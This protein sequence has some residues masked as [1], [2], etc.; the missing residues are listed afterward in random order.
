MHFL[1]SIGRFQAPQWPR[2]R[3][4][5][6][7]WRNVHEYWLG[8]TREHPSDLKNNMLVFHAASEAE[9]AP[10]VVTYSILLLCR[11]SA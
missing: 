3:F 11:P 2:I 1:P 4:G 5:W 10:G 7:L 6:C 9:N 8:L